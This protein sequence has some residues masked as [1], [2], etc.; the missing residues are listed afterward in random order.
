M[1]EVFGTKRV[2]EKFKH[3]ADQRQILLDISKTEAEEEKRRSD[4]ALQFLNAVLFATEENAKNIQLGINNKAKSRRTD[5]IHSVIINL[6]HAQ[7]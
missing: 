6:L 2:E 4:K 1:F 3:Y 7:H 5:T